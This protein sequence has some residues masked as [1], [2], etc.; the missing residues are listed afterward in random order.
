MSL[1]SQLL[2]VSLCLLSL[3]WAG[4]QYLREMES[5]LREG[6]GMAAAATAKALAAALSEREDLLYPVAERLAGA[7]SDGAWYVPRVG[8]PLMADG[9][10]EDWQEL[11]N[12]EPL[13]DPSGTAQLRLGVYQSRLY[14]LL[15][16]QDSSLRYRTPGLN[17]APN[18]DRVALHCIDSLGASRLYVIATAAPG[19]V[20][21]APVRGGADRF[22]DRVRGAWRE[23]E[24]G[25]TVELQL[26]LDPHCQRLS[27][28]VV[29]AGPDGEE[30]RFESR[31]AFG[32]TLPWLVTRVNALDTWLTAFS[33]AGRRIEIH[34]SGDLLVGLNESDAAASRPDESEVFWLLR[35]LYRAMLRGGN[36]V[37]TGYDTQGWYTTPYSRSSAILLTAETSIGSVNN[38]LG[39]VV[40]QETTERY[41]AL[42][43]RASTRVFAISA[44]VLASAFAALLGFATVLSI[45][46]RRLRD[47]AHSVAGDE[48]SAEDFPRSRARDELGELSRSYGELL[49]QINDYNRYLRGLARTLSHELRTPIAVVGSSIEHVEQSDLDA[50]ERDEYLARAREGLRRLTRIVSAMSEASR[51][52]ESLINAPMESL[53]LNPLL[54]QLRDAYATTF[55]GM[56]FALSGV[57]NA[58]EVR[59]N[60]DLIAQ[61]LDKLVDNAVSFAPTGS[62]IELTLAGEE[63]HATVTVANLGPPLP[64]TL[65]SRLFE[66]M[67]SMR[68]GESKSDGD[69]HLG[70]GLFITRAIAEAHGGELLAEN[71]RSGDGAVFTLRLPLSERSAAS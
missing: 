46:I 71:L 59:G 21:A 25:Y 16:V 68:D 66:P 53:A 14:L 28:A 40:I 55:P 23:R 69:S 1:R 5:T 22:A 43:D 60:G 44:A 70:L 49:E 56:S 27:V 37:S 65:R 36:T 38:T 52:E 15:R 42:T 67:V 12:I 3:P 58:L 50:E 4:C 54:A 48:L 20:R 17:S 63:E 51:I 9:Y 2:L 7:Q 24:G 29:D 45:R 10:G 35:V 13:R 8:R 19:L 31:Q 32:D 30:V 62:T 11:E 6:Q 47:A 18:G 34:D 33:E 57:G 26:P 39:K 61:A 41:L 64:E